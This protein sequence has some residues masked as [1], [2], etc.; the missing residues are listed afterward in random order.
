MYLTQHTTTVHLCKCDVGFDLVAHPRS[1]TAGETATK[2]HVPR[3]KL[4][5]GVLFCDRDSYTL[6]AVPSSHRVDPSALAALLGRS[7]LLLASEDELLLMFPDCELGA[8]PALGAPYGIPTVVDAALL[9][10]PDVYMEAGDH[11]HLL[12]V[13]GNDFRRLMHGAPRGVISHGVTPFRADRSA[14]PC[15]SR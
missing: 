14:D 1:L 12:H 4:A 2:A 9:V 5:K 8:V 11:R 10:E 3:H 7:E 6:A 13:A 15:L